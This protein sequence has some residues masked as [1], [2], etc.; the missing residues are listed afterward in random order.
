MS[1]SCSILLGVFLLPDLLH[2]FSVCILS[3]TC[4][5]SDS[6]SRFY[7]D[8]STLCPQWH[9]QMK[10]L[11]PFP[12][13]EIFPPLF[14]QKVLPLVKVHEDCQHPPQPQLF[15]S[16]ELQYHFVWISLVAL[17]PFYLIFNF[18]LCVSL[19]LLDFIR[20]NSE[21]MIKSMGLNL[22]LLNPHVSMGNYWTSLRFSF[23]TCN[24]EV[25]TVFTSYNYC[26]D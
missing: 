14:S 7:L 9:I 12:P 22:L 18:F 25:V 10:W 3:L 1:L 26:E 6:L 2:A 5:G 23:L 17:T 11:I 21:N 13:A 4:H 24:M 16:P 20:W 19:F 15:P 8:S